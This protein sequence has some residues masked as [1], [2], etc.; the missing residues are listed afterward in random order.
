MEN[1]DTK[2][3][4]LLVI[5]GMMY[6]HAQG[7]CVMFSFEVFF[8]MINFGTRK[9]KLLDFLCN[10]LTFRKNLPKIHKISIETRLQKYLKTVYIWQAK[11]EKNTGFLL[12]SLQSFQLFMIHLL[13]CDSKWHFILFS[14][15]ALY[16][17]LK[18]VPNSIPE[19]RWRII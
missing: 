10:F 2:L 13:H 16:C 14:L 4:E 8:T 1:R 3:V 5:S 19:R 11:T 17:T 18:Y 9:C 15:L 6:P 7:W 12:I